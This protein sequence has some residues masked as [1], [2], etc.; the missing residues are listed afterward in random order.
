MT[1]AISRL[2]LIQK[3]GLGV[4]F[5]GLLLA[6]TKTYESTTYAFFSYTG[7][8]SRYKTEDYSIP[9]FIYIPSLEISLPIDETSINYGFWGVS[10][11]GVSH[12]T[13]TSVPGLDGNTV[14]YGK[15]NADKFGRVTNLRKGDDILITTK[16]GTIHYYT[17]SDLAIVSPTESALIDDTDGETLTLFT[18]YGFGDLKRFVVRATPISS[19]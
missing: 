14:I 3:I 15:N 2:S 8:L 19:E 17:V 12:L 13:S 5:M 6:L 16:D 7:S 1:N 11:D 9:T 18:S 4:V 10:S